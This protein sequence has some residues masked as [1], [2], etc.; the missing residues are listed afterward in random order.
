MSF[1]FRWLRVLEAPNWQAAVALASAVFIY[2]SGKGVIQNVEPWMV[3][4]AWGTFLVSSML[5]LVGITTTLSDKILIL[6]ASI[7]EK[8]R[9][10]RKVKTQIGYLKQ[11]EKDIIS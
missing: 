7:A 3:N 11:H 2:L 6:T 5:F 1:D 8:S 10:E 4:F 9:T